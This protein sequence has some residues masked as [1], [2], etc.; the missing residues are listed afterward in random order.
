MEPTP[1]PHALGAFL[2][3]RGAQVDPQKCGLPTTDSPR[4]VPN[5]PA[6]PTTALY[7]DFS[8]LAP[9]WSAN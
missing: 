8:E 3:A 9:A 2:R 7:T 1:D 6:A 4:R 5:S